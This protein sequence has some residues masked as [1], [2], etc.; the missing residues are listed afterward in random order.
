MPQL[1][2]ELP[3]SPLPDTTFLKRLCTV[4]LSS[5][6]LIRLRFAAGRQR[7]NRLRV[8]HKGPVRG[9]ARAFQTWLLRRPVNDQGPRAPRM[10]P[11][12][13]IL[14]AITFLSVSV[15]I[16]ALGAAA[17]LRSA[18]EDVANAPWRPIET[19]ATARVD[20]APPTLA[21]LRV[22][23]ETATAT[24]AARADALAPPPASV[25]T[26][27]PASPAPTAE[28]SP[29]RAEPAEPAAVKSTEAPAAPTQASAPPPQAIAA[30]A[31]PAR[32]ATVSPA[33]AEI[34]V[35]EA[36][37]VETRA[38]DAKAADVKAADSQ[39]ADTKAAETVEP[40]PAPTVVAA[41]SSSK[42]EPAQPAITAEPASAT[43]TPP[44][45]S[46]AVASPAAPIETVAGTDTLKAADKTI[47]AAPASRVAAL[48]EPDAD[49]SEPLPSKDVKIPNP[50]V[51]PAVLEARR[52]Q[53]LAQEQARARALRARRIAAARARAAAQAKAAAA[54]AN[55]FGAPANSTTNNSTPN[56]ARTN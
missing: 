10:L 35:P 7:F 25:E 8:R 42:V 29:P 13:R 27:T 5:S 23:P 20:L 34:K 12:L 26:K 11:G 40:Q 55:P 31:E 51:D 49:Q 38:T 17:F 53:I 15:L 33:V 3:T 43:T 45:T 36:K 21:M 54:A 46:P 16:F 56:T 18:H 9:V 4:A 50:R 30:A 48:G 52:K 24:P 41:L 39:A 22:E 28:A 47:D 19:P 37:V 6:H 1:C 44:A 2:G 14:F 32:D